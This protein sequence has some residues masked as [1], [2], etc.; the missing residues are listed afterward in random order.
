MEDKCSYL[1][2]IWNLFDLTGLSL[3]G[4]I[5]AQTIFGLSYIS[6][7]K[8][9]IMGAFACFSLLIKVYDWLRLF[10]PTA[11]LILLVGRILHDVRWFMLLFVVAMLIFGIPLSMLN[12][13]RENQ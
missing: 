6:M 13:N 8:L 1:K 10:Q 9:R 3:T 12:L 4:C 2:N 5:V 11:Y 7:D